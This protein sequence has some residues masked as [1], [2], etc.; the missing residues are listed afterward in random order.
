[1]FANQGVSVDTYYNKDGIVRV[2]E[3]NDVSEVDEGVNECVRWSEVSD[4]YG[5]CGVRR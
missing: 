2:N 1:M 4:R 3:V 5:C